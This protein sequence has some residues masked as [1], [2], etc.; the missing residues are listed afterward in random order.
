MLYYTSWTS[1]P[2][3]YVASTLL[4]TGRGTGSIPVWSTSKNASR[5]ASV[6]RLLLEKLIF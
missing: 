1:G 6:F 4:L 3:V 5:A 2:E